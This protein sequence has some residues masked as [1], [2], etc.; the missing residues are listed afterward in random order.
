MRSC[1][2][3]RCNFK[4]PEKEDAMIWANSMQ[5]EKRKPYNVLVCTSECKNPPVRSRRKWEDNIKMDLREMGW[6]VMNWFHLTLDK[7][8]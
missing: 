4:D 7:N 8:Q 6:C 2:L 5:R 3:V 1:A